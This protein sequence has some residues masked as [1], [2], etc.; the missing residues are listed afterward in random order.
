MDIADAIF[1]RAIKLDS[2][3]VNKKEEET[4]NTLSETRDECFEGV[5]ATWRVIIDMLPNSRVEFTQRKE[6]EVDRKSVV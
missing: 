4:A 2:I 3:K 5:I 6:L 1:E